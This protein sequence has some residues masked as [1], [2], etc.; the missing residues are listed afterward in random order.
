MRRRSKPICF[1]QPGIRARFPP[2]QFK[3]TDG[4]RGQWMEADRIRSNQS[5]RKQPSL[6]CLTGG[7]RKS[8]PLRGS[9]NRK[10]RSDFLS[11]N[12]FQS[13]IPILFDGS[14]KSFAIGSLRCND[15][16]ACCKSKRSP[17]LLAFL[18]W[19]LA[20]ILKV[21]SLW[22]SRSRILLREQVRA[23]P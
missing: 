22:G 8:H 9:L 5:V 6:S 12:P 18:L 14:K 4:W 7:F 20:L 21:R 16:S 11:G 17:R 1:V 13:M 3:R 15:S 23:R 2:L 19:P 10:D